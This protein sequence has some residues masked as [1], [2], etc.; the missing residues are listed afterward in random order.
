MPERYISP[1][2]A[3]DLQY[4][5]PSQT[6]TLVIIYCLG[7]FVKRSVITTIFG[8]PIIESSWSWLSRCG[9]A[10]IRETTSVGLFDKRVSDSAV[11]GPVPCYLSLLLSV[12]FIN[13]CCFLMSC[14]LPSTRLR[15][16]CSLF[17]LTSIWPKMWSNWAF[18]LNCFLLPLNLN[19]AASL[20]TFDFP[21]SCLLFLSSW[22]ARYCRF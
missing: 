14:L 15:T 17:R 10:G 4:G 12:S 13:F 22:G 8:C 3:F 5:R 11:L 19:S 9:T 7:K 18:N 2:T 6:F 1:Q 20:T 16:S 21:S